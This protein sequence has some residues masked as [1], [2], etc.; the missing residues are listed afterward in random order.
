[1]ITKEKLIKALEKEGIECNILL[2]NECDFENGDND[3][4]VF[5]SFEKDHVKLEDPTE[6]SINAETESSSLVECLEDSDD[7]V[8]TVVWEIRNDYKQWKSKG[9]LYPKD[10]L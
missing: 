5:Y 10:W 1:M 3:V 4:E 7:D 6:C 8:S 9:K 2:F